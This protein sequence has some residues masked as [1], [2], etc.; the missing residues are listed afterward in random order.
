MIEHA[1][2]IELSTLLDCSF[3]QAEAH[4]RTPRLLEYVA[5]P[6]IRFTPISPGT[7]PKQW[8]TGTHWVGLRILGFLPF[9][10]QA[11]VISYPEAVEGFLLRDNGHSALVRVWDHTITI[12]AEAGRTWYTDTV[13]I[14][15]GLLTLPIW[16][17]AKV[18]YHHRQRRWRKLVG[19][20]FQY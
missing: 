13:N 1:M 9:G 7:F 15:A 17:F 11:I 14:N 12:K 4:V 8:S 20:S 5:Y 3:E 2:Q 6:L 10:K 19:R 16:L 18:F